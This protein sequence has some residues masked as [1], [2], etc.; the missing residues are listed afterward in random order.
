MSLITLALTIA[1]VGFF[2]WL[3]QQI[4]MPAVFHNIII[5]IVC[6]VLILWVLQVMGV[7]TGLPTLRLR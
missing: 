3:I 7:H 4:P 5:G 2:C 6:V 1:L